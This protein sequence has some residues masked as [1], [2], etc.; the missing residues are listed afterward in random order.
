MQITIKI[1]EKNV[2]KAF[3]RVSIENPDTGLEREILRFADD[4]ENQAA[5]SIKETGKDYMSL[6]QVANKMIINDLVND[7]NSIRMNISRKIKH[8]SKIAGIESYLDD[9]RINPS[10][11]KGRDASYMISEEDYP[12]LEELFNREINSDTDKYWAA[13]GIYRCFSNN[14]RIDEELLEDIG[15][16]ISKRL[17][18]FNLKYS[19]AI[20]ERTENLNNIISDTV[21]CCKLTSEER[22]ERYQKIMD[23]LDLLI[24]SIK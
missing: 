6:N 10:A 16:T 9:L 12:F 13:Q 21:S 22:K 24:G 18:T 20:K 1:E 23:S 11:K 17:N 4:L 15:N 14:E 19:I 8:I 3:K 7:P 5:I 2:N